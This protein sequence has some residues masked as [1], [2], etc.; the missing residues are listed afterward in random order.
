ME[1][2]GAGTPPSAVSELWRGTIQIQV[3]FIH[4][5]NKKMK[6]ILPFTIDNGKGETIAFREI[7]R[8]PDGD[9]LVLE[10]RCQ[11]NA[12]P[13]M[14]VHY[15]QDEVITVVKGKMACQIL[16]E[17]PQYYTEGQTAT[18]LRNVPHRFW[19]AGE[20]ELVINGWVKPANSI[21]FFLTTLYAAQ[22]RSKSSQPEAYDAAYLMI[23]YKNEYGLPELPAFVKK[24]IMPVTYRLGLILG[25]YKKFKDAPA[26]L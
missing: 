19:N 20:E 16:G 23:R 8:E 25:M 5:K 22:K 18:F 10:G 6:N 12:G 26:P 9:K 3:I 1:T 13:T 24:I 4:E 11:P 15:K 14:H 21:V 17:A 2:R 7:I